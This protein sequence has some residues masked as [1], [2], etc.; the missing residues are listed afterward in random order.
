MIFGIDISR[1]WLCEAFLCETKTC[2]G[3]AMR[4]SWSQ[5]MDY[6][7]YNTSHSVEKNALEMGSL[8]HLSGKLSASVICTCTI[9]GCLM[10]LTL[11][12]GS[13]MPWWLN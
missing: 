6:L 5:K 10:A 11:K 13:V 8:Q 7:Q 3:V 2:L 12:P 1:A 9:K 4:N